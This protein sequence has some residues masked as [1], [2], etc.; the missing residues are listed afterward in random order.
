MRI[1][2]LLRR[3]RFFCKSS[4][5]GCRYGHFNFSKASFPTL[6]SF[7]PHDF[8]MPFCNVNSK[9][10]KTLEHSR[11]ISSAV[12]NAV[13]LAICCCPSCFR[14][15]PSSPRTADVSETSY[16]RSVSYFTALYK[17]PYP[18]NRLYVLVRLGDCFGKRVER[19]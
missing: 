18:S 11:T 2:V 10:V 9:S 12:A 5:L 16:E 13:S 1:R 19:D 8:C 15:D 14:I 3:S 7:P 6:P 4:I 17:W